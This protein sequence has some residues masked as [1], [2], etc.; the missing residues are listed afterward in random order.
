M[1]LQP[2]PQIFSIT[3]YKGG[4]SALPGVAKPIK[5]A[6][7]E[8][9]KGAGA[10]AC[11]AFRAAGDRLALYPDGGASALRSALADHHGVEADKIVC[12]SGSDEIF[13]LLGRAFLAPG[14]EIIQSEHAFL[15]YRLVAQTAGAVTRTALDK[16]LVVDVEAMLE[17]VGPKT[18]IVFLANPNNPTGTFVPAA[19]V[20]RLHA[21]LP[22][23][24][25]LVLDAAYA[26]YVDDPAYES[27]L[28]LA[29]RHANVLMT[30]T[31][32]KIYGLAALRLGWAYGAPVAI[33]ALNRVRGPFNVGAPAL[34]AGAAALADQAFVDASRAENA[35]ERARVTAALEGMGLQVTPSVCN[36]VLVHFPKA[37]GRNAPAADAALRRAGVI[38]RR[39]E[40][41]GLGGALRVSIGAPHENDAL[42][43][44]L[45]DFQGAA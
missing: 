31:F 35:A 27:G 16:D 9:P 43:N 5:L 3:P 28:E 39:M 23:N 6:S 10:A 15:V 14:D 21:G 12:G 45:A 22:E 32:S 24:V 18:K 41:Y 34:A 29:R 7:N 11:A 37:E 40:A 2:L 42:I 44:G 38:V 19:D 4:E 8:N 17:L 33:D 20:A 36:F 25:L 13:Q 30:R 26:E 1:S